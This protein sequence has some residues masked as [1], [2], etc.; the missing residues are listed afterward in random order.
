M[1]RVIVN[2]VNDSTYFSCIDDGNLL[3]RGI[4]SAL[5]YILDSVDN[6]LPFQD[7]T[8]DDLLERDAV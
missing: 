7:F 8:K 2:S 1:S 6:F 5:G 4:T 3:Y